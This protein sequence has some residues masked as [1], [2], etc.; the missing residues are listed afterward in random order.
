MYYQLVPNYIFIY[1][2]KIVMLTDV[3][4]VHSTSIDVC[5]TFKSQPNPLLT[6]ILSLLQ[7]LIYSQKLSENKNKYIYMHTF[8]QINIH[9]LYACLCRYIYISF[10]KNAQYVKFYY[11]KL[12]QLILPI[13]FVFQASQSVH[14]FV[15]TQG[16]LSLYFQ[17]LNFCQKQ[18]LKKITQ[19]HIVNHQ[20]CVEYVI[21]KTNLYIPQYN[22]AFQNQ[23]K[24]WNILVLLFQYCE[25]RLSLPNFLKLSIVLFS[26]SKHFLIILEYIS[27]NF[28]I[29]I[30]DQAHQ[31]YSKQVMYIVTCDAPESSRENFSIAFYCLQTKKYLNTVLTQF[32][33]YPKSFQNFGS[34][35][36]KIQLILKFVLALQGFI[37]IV[38]WITIAIVY[39]LKLPIKRNKKQQYEQIIFIHELQVIFFQK[40]LKNI[41]TQ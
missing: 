39:R 25:W 27:F 11:S 24:T 23:K 34:R 13:F 5:I 35:R 26:I 22:S 14:L 12:L 32:L 20:I 6:L 41:K 30:A 36:L 15:I 28:Q 37:Q 4:F 2:L 19:V 31:I 10:N 8:V 16:I 29:F 18:Q 3:F 21:Q 17:S 38:F 33:F 9:T 7:S 1:L 40:A